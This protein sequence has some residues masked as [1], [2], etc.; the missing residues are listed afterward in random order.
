MANP[1][2]KS[3]TLETD[4]ELQAGAG[5]DQP[6]VVHVCVDL[7]NVSHRAITA[8][9]DIAQA[10]NASL[11]LL[12]V[13]EPTGGDATPLPDPVEWDIRRQGIEQQLKQIAKTLP[14]GKTPVTVRVLEGHSAQQI[15]S[16]LATNP[17]DIAVICRNNNET[18]P[19][20]GATAQRILEHGASTV[21]MVPE[22]VGVTA[23]DEHLTR[24]MLA[25][26]G[27]DQSETAIPLSLRLASAKDAELILVHATP[28]PALTLAGPSEPQDKA[29]LDE[30]RNRNRR[31]AKTY[32]K[33]KMDR[34]KSSGVKLRTLILS[35]S[36]VRRALTTGAQDEHADLFI[37]ASHGQSGFGD[38]AVG[39]VANFVIRH[40]PVPV[41]LVRSIAPHGPSH[42]YASARTK[43][44]RPPGNVTQ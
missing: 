26:D 20:L 12:H 41:L 9:Q 1:S 38:V 2:T 18:G 7:A 36:D 6:Q 33:Q 39:D 28:E 27:S 21:L 22:T 24:I 42:V 29:L 15:C 11:S 5:D 16:T 31:V 17:H 13:I 14:E 4:T 10:L 44:A 43:G 32:L 3:P 30:L 34:L 40:A 35:G 23:D 37:I 8:G 25:L 19:C